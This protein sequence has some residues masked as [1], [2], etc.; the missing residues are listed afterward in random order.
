MKY[1]V[2]RSVLSGRASAPGSKSLMQRF[3]AG[4]LMSRGTTI[5]RNPQDSADAIAALATAELLGADLARDHDGNYHITGGKMPPDQA[6]NV[7]E[8]GLAMRLFTPIAAMSGY[9]ITLTGEG[10]LL[11]RPIDAF[12]PVFT[13]MG[14]Y[15]VS[16]DGKLPITVKGPLLGGSCS[17]DGSV[18]SQFLSGLLMALPLAQN[19]STIEVHGLKSTPYVDMT[20]EVLEQFGIQVTH[21][22]YEHF[23]IPGNQHYKPADLTCEGDWSGAAALLVAAALAGSSSNATLGKNDDGVVIDNL[24]TTYTQADSRITGVLMFAGARLLNRKG[25]ISMHVPKLRG[26]DFDATDAPDLFPVLAALAT[27]GDRPSRIAGVHRLI[28]K[29]SNRATAIATEF[30]KAGIEVRIDGDTM[31][32]VPGVP[33]PAE[34]S[35]QGDHRMAMAAALLGLRSDG[36]A[37]S[38]AESVDKSFPDFFHLLRELGAEIRRVND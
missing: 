37:I 30:G 14:A 26:F 34:L 20:L 27:A 16:N 38:G 6:L 24:N 31:V 21:K 25:S 36:I 10:S 11:R 5:I 29:E 33:K 1:R 8:S 32:I 19:D 15:I 23:H 3:I 22:N 35:S 18:S 9:D 4:A 28:H 12:E 13:A 2:S 17:L 7:G